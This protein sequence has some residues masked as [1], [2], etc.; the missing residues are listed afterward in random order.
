MTMHCPHCREDNTATTR[1]CIACGAV[2]VESTPGGGRRRVLRPWGL[3]SS[4]PLTESP[5]LPE[6]AAARKAAQRESGGGRTRRLYHWIGGLAGVV[7]LSGVIAYPYATQENVGIGRSAEEAFAKGTEQV[8]AIAEM[9]AVRERIP[10]TPP[11]EPPSTEQGTKAP[12]IA[13]PPRPSARPAATAAEPASSVVREPIVE[14]VVVEAPPASVVASSRVVPVD[15]WQTL[16]DSLGACGRA[17]GLWER[18][19]CEQRAR[20]AHCDGH[21]GAVALCPVGRTDHGQ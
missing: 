2:L 20:L 15:P 18:A 10:S 4:A 19:T 6:M 12:R 14:P 13:D 11:L 8:V 21:W 3:L 7:T 16:R 9:T 17:S 1:F 5:A